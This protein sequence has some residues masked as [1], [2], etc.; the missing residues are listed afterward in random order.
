MQIKTE[1]L[2]LTDSLKLLYIDQPTIACSNQQL[3]VA[4]LVLA[5]YKSNNKRQIITVPAGCGKTRII[6]SFIILMKKVTTNRDVT[7]F[8]LT[9]L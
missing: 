3:A 2:S 1:V 8:S 9:K 5:L 7:S 6:M 4:S